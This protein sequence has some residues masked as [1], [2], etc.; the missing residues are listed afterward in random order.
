MAED[1]D[2]HDSA[3]A[4]IIEAA[5]KSGLLE[6][7]AGMLWWVSKL[8]RSYRSHYGTCPACFLLDDLTEAFE[9]LGS[10]PAFAVVRAFSC[11]EGE[12]PD[13]SPVTPEEKAE[14]AAFID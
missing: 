9:D 11:K 12:E 2:I 4:L 5:E 7:V 1:K 13:P 8:E 14:A 6:E 3:R 10:S